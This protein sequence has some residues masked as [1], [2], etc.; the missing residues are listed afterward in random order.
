MAT[1][2]LIARDYAA[3]MS[4]FGRRSP[5]R[6][7]AELAGLTIFSLGVDEPWGLQVIAVQAEPNIG[8]VSE[9][10]SWCRRRCGRPPQIVVREQHRGRFPAYDVNE[11]LVA[12]VAPVARTDVAA[13]ALAVESA[14]DVAEFRHVYGR[15][16]D[17]RAG[18]VDALVLE[19]DLTAL[20]HLL[21][22]VD[23]RAVACAQVRAGHQL[24]LV[25]GVGVLPEHRGH[26]YGT[27][28]LTACREQAA[29]LGCELV[30]LNAEPQTAPFYEGI[31]F[32]RV[33]TY[34][35]LMAS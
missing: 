14:A 22:R 17:M 21:G 35:A 9:A 25:S 2:E 33:D 23:G 34:V 18:L 28:M 15:S 8:A 29:E 10:V 13:P 1:A 30:W 3:R 24:A 12:L 31:G 26:G 11:T 27:A 19:A 6:F 32:E 5:D 20:P 4:S 16:F 7:V